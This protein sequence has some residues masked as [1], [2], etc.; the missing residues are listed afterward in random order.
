MILNPF[1]FT[2]KAAFAHPVLHVFFEVWVTRLG[3]FRVGMEVTWEPLWVWRKGRRRHRAFLNHSP[4]KQR[5]YAVP[6]F[7]HLLNGGSEH[8]LSLCHRV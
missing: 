6:Q 5:P 8:L 1:K 4:R 7:P 3:P 2:W